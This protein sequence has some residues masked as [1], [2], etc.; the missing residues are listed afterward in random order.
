MNTLLLKKLA[1]LMRHSAPRCRRTLRPSPCIAALLL[2]LCMT[3][4]VRSSRA[5]AVGGSTGPGAA[6]QEKLTLSPPLW[7]SNLEEEIG[8]F[9]AFAE[10][11]L[12]VG[13][14]TDLDNKAFLAVL[15]EFSR[16]TNA[17]DLSVLQ[18]F[19]EGNPNSPWRA[20]L[21]SDLGCFLKDHG[22]FTRAL[23]AWREAWELT[24][25]SDTGTARVIA[26]RAGAEYVRLAA[27][28]GRVDDLEAMLDEFNGRRFGPAVHGMVSEARGK[29][30]TMRK[31][32]TLFYSCG[33]QALSR[34]RDAAGK[35]VLP[36]EITEARATTNG[37]SLLD[38]QLLA[39]RI[40]MDYQ[41]AKRTPGAS[42][43]VPAV[44]HL[45]VGHYVALTREHQGHYLIQDPTAGSR[46]MWIT[47]AA[48]DDESSGYC[49]VRNGELP[50]G[51]QSVGESEGQAIRGRGPMAEFDDKHLKASDIKTGGG[52]PPG[53]GMPYYSFHTMMVSL[54]IQDTPLGYTPVYGPS[55]EFTVTYNQRDLTQPSTWTYPNLGP[56]WTFNWLS[57]VEDDATKTYKDS[58]TCYLPGG[59]QDK[60]TY[61][62][63]S[64]Q[65]N[66]DPDDRTHLSR[67]GAW[68]NVSSYSVAYPDGSVIFYE[69]CNGGS[70]PRRF[71]MT[72]MKDPQGN[73]LTFAWL[74]NRLTQVQD[75]RGTATSITYWS[76]NSTE[77]DYYKIWKVTDPF[78]R[79]AVLEYDVAA[80]DCTQLVK[81][82]DQ[83]GMVSTFNY[84]PDGSGFII[85]MTTPYGTTSFN[86]GESLQAGA[87][88][89][90][91]SATDPLGQQER[92]EFNQDP[93][94]TGIATSDDVNL[95][96]TAP[97]PFKNLNLCFRNSFFWSKQVMTEIGGIITP[98]SYAK[99]DIYHWCHDA[100]LNASSATL[101]SFKKPLENRIWFRYPGQDASAD[102][103]W[104]EG[105]NTSPCY[106]ARVLDDGQTR[107]TQLWQCSYNDFGKVTAITNPVGRVTRWVY[108]DNNIDL[109]E[110]RQDQPASYP[111][112]P[113]GG[114]L[115]ARFA[116]DSTYPRLVSTMTDASGQTTTYHYGS[117]GQLSEII[118]AKGKST[119]FNY[120]YSGHPGFLH[121]IVG[122]VA[123][124]S[125]VFTPDANDRVQTLT[126]PAAS[127]GS[128]HTVTY[129]Y[130]DFD[131]V[132]TVT[133]P[134]TTTEQVIYSKLDPVL[135]KDRQDR[136][137]GYEYDP[138]RRLVASKDSLGRVIQYNWCACSALESIIDSRT[139]VTVWARDIQGR[140]TR[141]TYPDMSHTDYTYDGST[142]RIT[143][144]TDAKGQTTHYDYNRDDTVLRISYPNALIPTP[145]V[146]FAYDP[147]YSRIRTMTDGTGVTT[148]N[149]NPITTTPALGAGRLA[150]VS[151]PLP[152][153]TVSFTYD[154]LGRA[155]GR[156]IASA[157]L[158]LGFDDL[159]RVS[160]I[161]DALG[162]FTCSYDGGTPRVAAI[163]GGGLQVDYAYYRSANLRDQERLQII[164]NQFAGNSVSKFDYT[165]TA[166]GQITNWTRQ[167]DAAASTFYSFQYDAVD[168]LVGANLT[169]NTPASPEALIQQYIYSYD[170][171]GNRTTMSLDSPA[172]A[173][174]AV[175]NN[176]NEL[177]SRTTGQRVLFAGTTTP[178]SGRTTRSVT[179][180]GVPAVMTAPTTFKGYAAVSS[181]NNIVTVEA[182]DSDGNR[183][184]KRYQVSTGAG[185]T[186]S[187]TYD[188]NGNLH[189]SITGSTTDT[190]EWDAAD[191]LVAVNH[192][193]GTA[194]GTRSE[195]T[196]DGLGR[197]VRIVERNASGAVTSDKRYVWCGIGICE[198]RNAANTPLK[199]Y[200]PQGVLIGSDKYFYTRDH[201][202]SIRELVD[203]SGVIR[204]RYDYDPYGKR[205][206][207]QITSDPVEADFGFTGHFFHAP[208]SLHLALLRAYDTDTGRWLSRDPIGEAGGLNLYAYV[209]NNPISSVDPFGLS[210]RDTLRDI[211]RG[212][213]DFMMGDQSGRYNQFTKGALDA[214]MGVVDI[215]RDNNVL[216]ESM[217]GAAETIGVMGKEA[218]QAYVGGKL[219]EA[220]LGVAGA[221]Y[222]RARSALG[223]AK[224]TKGV[225]D[226]VSKPRTVEEA[227][228][229]G[230]K[231]LGPGYKELGQPGSGVYRSADEL[232]QFRMTDADIAGIHGGKPVKIGPHVH[233]EKF[234]SAGD[235]LKNI[236]TPLID[237]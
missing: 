143:D 192:R 84:R 203:S 225:V 47:M 91:L 188:L 10:P 6:A 166:V 57:Y 219:A 101:E 127:D 92:L 152:A 11:L 17:E 164:N 65:F 83:M 109:E 195:F 122:P 18:Q 66:A 77:P 213:Y 168:Q 103:A 233:F 56:K 199:Q 20:S 89:R 86:G 5:A 172:A 190:Y 231:W 202:G 9:H 232:R 163:T 4:S 138:Q 71:F 46:D 131:R 186:T 221:T 134:D 184:T 37:L 68:P 39:N 141:K 78:N 76:E 148:Y 96:P 36:P 165:Y 229:T 180:N 151:A 32:P 208:T 44:L 157:S 220:G 102:G 206:A 133:Y 82:T 67:N 116:Y 24:K 212:I 182:T 149:Y 181:A 38:V 218:A 222:C 189:S 95:V 123:G 214:Q 61:D 100:S 159:G 104:T 179:I 85:G 58:V 198:E 132:T 230:Q 185:T 216:R 49:L 90:W 1:S 88:Y 99:A 23:Q 125:L 117:H 50:A 130:D 87:A 150:S 81:I 234:N 129:D 160:S 33:P 105:T 155:A 187:L 70:S 120:G 177:T 60:Y 54:N 205:G 201:L 176:L 113:S 118:D 62:I 48:L 15:A 108:N 146:T 19:L 144:I 169:N 8:R 224:S 29:L 173:Y 207:N 74:N 211:G 80:G 14:T 16:R 237:P 51:W 93:A 121:S 73:E 34:I 167:F 145:S 235:K 114:N 7:A 228:T 31:K 178:A 204:A 13:K 136:W 55:V 171:A 215:D 139:N 75:A 97:L 193:T 22:Y 21:L 200:S 175:F 194:P 128:R 174:T 3:A 227:L 124:A 40:Q 223:A 137:T 53:T 35:S 111:G 162:N 209:G 153:S 59:G 156:T 154:E 69:H 106:I 30:A 161:S 112:D 183:N 119:T 42:V 2:L 98:S 210:W 64:S 217:G 135:V 79:Q 28:V 41:M 236:H 226:V 52:C 142:S 26:D 140:V 107:Q 94:Q 63:P 27:A 197:R 25:G 191:R 158:S 126:G 110:I 170:D 12:P 72:R 43:I 196:Y 115:L 45:K 147:R